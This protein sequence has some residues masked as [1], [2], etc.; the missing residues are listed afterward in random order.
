MTNRKDRCK[1]GFLCSARTISE[2]A[3]SEILRGSQAPILSSLS[4]IVAT[5]R[6]CLRTPSASM[7]AWRQSSAGPWSSEIAMI[8]PSS[9]EVPTRS[10]RSF[11][12]PA[13]VGSL[14]TGKTEDEPEVPRSAQPSSTQSRSACA[15]VALS[16]ASRATVACAYSS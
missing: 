7:R 4:S 16:S 14:Q 1:S 11:L 13:Y 10:I 5:W 6:H 2:D 9:S 15:Q 12:A 3:R 8:P